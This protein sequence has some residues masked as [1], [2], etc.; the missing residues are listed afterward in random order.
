MKYIENK[1]QGLEMYYL[2]IPHAPLEQLQNIENA[3]IQLDKMR[4]WGPGLQDLKSQTSQLT[5][6][7]QKGHDLEF[8]LGSPIF[9]LKLN[10]IAAQR[11]SLV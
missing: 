9:P 5:S 6:R 4:K 10:Y 7:A 3:T 2:L 11:N 1:P 8:S